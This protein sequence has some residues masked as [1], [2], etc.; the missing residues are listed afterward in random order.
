MNRLLIIICLLITGCQKKEAVIKKNIVKINRGMGWYA[1]NKQQ[2]DNQLSDYLKKADVAQIKKT[3]AMIV[4][5][6]GY[7]YS[8]QTAAFAFKSVQHLNFKR[9]LVIGPSHKYH[10]PN[11]IVVPVGNVYQTPL[12]ESMID[13]EFMDK[14]ISSPNIRKNPDAF[15][16]EHSVDNEIPFVQKLFP[17]ARLVPIIV[18]QLNKATIVELGRVIKPLLDKDTL[19][20]VSS[21]FTHFGSSFGYVPFAENIEANLKK[22]AMEAFS[23]I[24]KIDVD[25]FIKFK[26][27]TG[28]TICGFMPILLLLELLP[29]SS[30]AQLAKFNT[31]GEMTKSFDHSVSYMSIIFTGEWGMNAGQFLINETEKTNLLKLSR[32]TLES[33]ITKGARPPIEQLDVQISENLK[34]SKA[35]GFVTLHKNGQLRGCIGEIFPTRDVVSVVLQRTIDAAV[36]DHRFPRVQASE[37]KDIDIEISILTPPVSVNSYQDIVIGKHGIVLEKD[38]KSAVFL[39]QVAPEQGWDLATTLTHLS[40]KAGLG[41]TQWKEGTSF[42]VFE[43][44]VFQEK[45]IN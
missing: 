41:A 32:L 39:P 15:V 27:T 43:A 8:G 29:A 24:E 30:V 10:L 40:L 9:V 34:T 1:Q 12:A 22:L 33:Y 3:T 36:N 6:A 44:V 28:D 14:I 35:G 21:D 45:N 19:I 7:A 4:P 42:K 25:G 38:S 37:L 20:V 17:N 16:Q 18:G 23:H 26:Q 11:Q 2:L 13:E 5:H 31:S